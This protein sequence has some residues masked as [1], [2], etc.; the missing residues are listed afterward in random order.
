M[1]EEILKTTEEKMKKTISHLK[2]ELSS[3][4]AGKAS[5]SLLKPIKVNTTDGMKMNLIEM[6]HASVLNAQTIE[7]K[8]WDPA[9]VSA[10]EKALYGSSLGVTVQTAGVS[11]KVIFP[12]MNQEQREKMAKLLNT[13][14]QDSKNALKSIR[15]DSLKEFSVNEPS[16]EE[17]V[18]F[19]DRIQKIIDKFNKEVDSIIEDKKKQIMQL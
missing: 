2:E 14:A 7:I 5:V 10:M 18:K 1:A 17:E 6:G 15:H 9:Q 16:N 13:N 11:L 19:K 12:Q 4:Q 3:I 8:A